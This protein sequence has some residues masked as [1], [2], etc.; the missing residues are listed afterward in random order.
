MHN[1]LLLSLYAIFLWM[2]FYAF[3]V[4]GK[5]R[6][7]YLAP[8]SFLLIY[9]SLEL[10]FMYKVIGD[11]NVIPEMAL[12]HIDD[13]DNALLLHVV[14]SVI[15]ISFSLL[16]IFS[17]K[18]KPKLI[19]FIL[20]P[21][22]RDNY[23]ISIFIHIITLILA[24]ICYQFFLS[25]IGGFYYLISNLDSR[26]LIIQGTGYYQ[27]IYGVSLFLSIGYLIR[28]YSFNNKITIL[29]Y[30][31]I[32]LVSSL[33]FVI[34]A[35]LGGRKTAIL[36]VLYTLVMWNYNVYKLNLFTIKNSVLVFVFMVYFSIM[37]LFRVQGAFD[38]YTNNIDLLFKES[39]DN[40]F[41]FFNRFSELSRSL[42]VYSVFDVDN[43]WMGGSFIDLFYAPIPRGI[44]P[45][46]P[47]ID[48]GVY[49]YNI[50]HGIEVSPPSSMQGL[51]PVGWPLSTITNMYINFWFFGVAIGGV[52]TGIV[53]NYL[54][55][56]MEILEYSPIIVFLYAS[57]IFGDFALTNI[58]LVS[59]LTKFAFSILIISMVFAVAN[60]F[61]R[62]K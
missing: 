48:S 37:P 7:T 61:I 14:C 18:A 49:I 59:M 19:V 6:I 20:K 45:E 38:F 40:L 3:N 60:V 2:L 46:K 1:Y 57:A 25:S 55:R 30:I 35:S 33:A 11:L 54:Y 43:L 22:G 31:Y 23:K 42:L 56:A 15:F 9:T 4:I 39:F 13:F 5:K 24:L 41:L 21:I 8:L 53:L 27:A 29:N 52:I 58:K 50:A 36:F 44:F 34:F 47:P 17:F 12:I 16:T 28:A 62:R 51:L 10:P 26:N 32:M